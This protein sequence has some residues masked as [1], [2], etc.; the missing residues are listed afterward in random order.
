MTAAESD[1]KQPP[2]A[3]LQFDVGSKAAEEFEIQGRRKN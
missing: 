1:P 3:Q 2:E